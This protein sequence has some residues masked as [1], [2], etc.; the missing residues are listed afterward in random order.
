MIKPC[1]SENPAK[2]STFLLACNSTL[3][4]QELSF[5]ALTSKKTTTVRITIKQTATGIVV[6]TTVIMAPLFVV[7]LG[8]DEGVG[9]GVDEGVGKDVGDGVGNGVGVGVGVGV[10]DGVGDGVGTALQLHFETLL[11]SIMVLLLKS[12]HI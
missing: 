1:D 5:F 10:G 7:R 3:L 4:L 9:E 8:I 6:A 2:F 11:Q 12:L